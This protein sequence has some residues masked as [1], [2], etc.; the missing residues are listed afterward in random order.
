MTRALRGLRI[1]WGALV[2]SIILYVIVGE[3]VPHHQLTANLIIFRVVEIISFVTVGVLFLVRRFTAKLQAIA[4]AGP[5]DTHAIARWRGACI[6]GFALCEVL[7]LY[8]FVLRMQGFGLPQVA[9]FYLA[10]ML[11]LLWFVPRRPA[12]LN[13]AAG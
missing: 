8:G 13:M 3:I 11:L 6:A 7:A 9:P 2:S 12:L 1:L 4:A 5:E 10:G